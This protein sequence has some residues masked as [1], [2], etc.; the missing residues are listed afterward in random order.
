ME[1]WFGQYSEEDKASECAILRM[2]RSPEV[3]QRPGF[4]A[5]DGGAISRFNWMARSF[6]SPMKDE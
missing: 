3:A 6:S 1:A 5:Q 2:N 4:Q